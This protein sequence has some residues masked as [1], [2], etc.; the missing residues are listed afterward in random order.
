M[1]H[2][3]LQQLRNAFQAH[4]LC[5]G[6][7][8]PT[9]RYLLLFY[10]VECGLKMTYLR[11]RNLLSTDK[12]PVAAFHGHDLTAWV[13]ELQIPAKSISGKSRFRHKPSDVPQDITQV[14][15]VWRY[16]AKMVTEDEADVVKWLNSVASWIKEQDK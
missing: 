8:V 11:K 12:I 7:K 14:H 4:L 6:V 13:K 3:S 2:V 10:A 16:G 1:I 15:Q 5:D 9:S